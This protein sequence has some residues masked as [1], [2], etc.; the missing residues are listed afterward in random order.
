MCYS[1]DHQYRILAGLFIRVRVRLRPFY[2]PWIQTA[3]FSKTP[4]G[5]RARL[6]AKRHEPW[7]KKGSYI[8]LWYFEV[9]NS[10]SGMWNCVIKWV[11][12]HDSSKRREPFN[13]WQHYTP[14]GVDFEQPFSENLWS[15]ILK[16]SYYSYYRFLFYKFNGVLLA[17]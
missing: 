13:Q 15:I 10:S 12:P 11:I 8:S 5:E 17:L 1:T 2:S 6:T 14:K 4:A 9:K 3:R 16:F 7:M